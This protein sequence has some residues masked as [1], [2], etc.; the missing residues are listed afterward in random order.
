MCSGPELGT[1]T[2][3]RLTDKEQEFVFEGV[4]ARPVPSLLRGFSGEGTRLLLWVGRAGCVR[5]FW[6]CMLVHQSAGAQPVAAAQLHGA[7]ALC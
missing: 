2:V 5:R 7:A 1:E 6:T 4:E 3:L